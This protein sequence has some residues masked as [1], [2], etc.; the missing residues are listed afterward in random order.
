M[1]FA[2][3]DVIVLVPVILT[4]FGKTR[5]LAPDTVML[6]PTW[7]EAALVNTRFVRGVVPP[8]APLKEITP[9]V[10]AAKVK[11]VA[12]LS[13]LEKLILA[14]A[15]VPPAFVVSNVGVLVIA[16]GP[17]IVIAPPLV[18]MFPFTLIAVDPV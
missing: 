12:P 17:V 6:L 15:A 16:T 18:V 14:P 13:V 1:M 7:I 2:L 10:P 11:D 9:A 5:G 3:L 8:T 4:G